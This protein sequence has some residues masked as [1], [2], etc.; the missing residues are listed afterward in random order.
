MKK[1]HVGGGGCGQVS[2]KY[3]ASLKKDKS[4]VITPQYQDQYVIPTKLNSIG[5]YVHFSGKIFSTEDN[6]NSATRT[7][8]PN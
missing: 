7:R 4:I 1:S 5:Y 2:S 8:D 3:E 6:F